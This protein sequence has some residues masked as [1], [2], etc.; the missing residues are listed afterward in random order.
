VVTNP[1][2]RQALRYAIDRQQMAES[3]QAG[4]VPVAHTFLHPNEPEYRAVEP[5]ISKYEYD[6]RKAAQ[7]LEGLGYVKG[8]DGGYRDAGGQRLSV[9]LRTSPEQ[10]IQQKSV[11]AVGDHWQRL[12]IATEPLV[13]AAQR[14]RDREYVQTFPSFMLYRQPNDPPSLLVRLTSDQAPLPENDFV[15]RNH[16]RYQSAEFDSLINRYLTT[17]PRPERT[18]VLGQIVQHTTER[19]VLMG[20]FYDTEPIMVANRLTNV[21]ATKVSTSTPVWNVL[22]W[23]VR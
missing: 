1:Q 2:F 19:V 9:E 8:S 7:L 23:D 14:T 22:D 20:L 18:Q 6:P 15:G 5:S 21:A 16:P 4:L 3:L 12:G 11:L 17:I 13:M 10:D